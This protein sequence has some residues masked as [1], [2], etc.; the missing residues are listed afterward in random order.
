MLLKQSLHYAVVAMGV[1]AYVGL[2]LRAPGQHVGE[3]A[4]S[5]GKTGDAVNDV[6]GE[7]VVQPGPSFDIGICRL[8]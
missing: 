7:H 6:I 8:R 2:T 5:I 1:D 4:V 3:D